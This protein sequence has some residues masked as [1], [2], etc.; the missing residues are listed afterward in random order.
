M[1][2]RPLREPWLITKYA[3]HKCT[4]TRV[5]DRGCFQNGLESRGPHS[6]EIAADLYMSARSRVAHFPAPNLPGAHGGHSLQERLHRQ[7]ICVGQWSTQMFRSSRGGAAPIGDGPALTRVGMSFT[8]SSM[9]QA[10]SAL[11]AVI[12]LGPPRSP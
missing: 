8:V 9:W 11:L 7:V 4:G 3:A 5:G 12:L 1:L 2:Y 6:S 10:S